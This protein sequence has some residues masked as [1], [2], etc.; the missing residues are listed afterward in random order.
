M[1]CVLEQTFNVSENCNEIV[2]NVQ[3]QLNTVKQ[4]LIN[5]ISNLINQNELL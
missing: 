4:P 5:Q 1:D 2:T 3:Q